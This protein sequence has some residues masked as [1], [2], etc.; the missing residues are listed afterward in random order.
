VETKTKVRNGEKEEEAL[1]VQFAACSPLF[2]RQ[3]SGEFPVILCDKADVYSMG[4]V[5][6]KVLTGQFCRHST[7]FG[8]PTHLKLTQTHGRQ[9]ADLIA[10]MTEKDQF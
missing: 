9:V 4:C 8:S 2:G 6:F 5:L 3:Q 10:G 7:R 1:V